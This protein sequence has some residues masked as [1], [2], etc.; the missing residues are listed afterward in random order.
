MKFLKSISVF[1]CLLFFSGY[2]FS[3]YKMNAN[4][5]KLSTSVTINTAPCKVFEYL[6]NSNN[7]SDWSSF[8]NRIVPLEGADGTLGSIR[9]CYKTADTDSWKWDEQTLL[10]DQCKKRKLSIYN[11]VNFPMQAPGLY[12][13]QIYQSLKGEKCKL[14][15]TLFFDKNES[16]FDFMRMKFTAFYIEYIFEKN[17]QNIKNIIE[18]STNEYTAK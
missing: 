7:A 13:E 4:K 17:L 6:G 15:F 3:P 2:V 14:T 18:N 1:S 10:L 5:Y 12:T 16:W 8:V 11:L 9:R